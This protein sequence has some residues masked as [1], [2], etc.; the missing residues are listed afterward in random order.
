MLLDVLRG[1][2]IVKT[3]LNDV[4]ISRAGYARLIAVKASVG[5]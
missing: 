4:V 2:D 3:A 5:E 1:G